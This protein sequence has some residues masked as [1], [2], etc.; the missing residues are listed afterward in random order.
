MKFH[1]PDMSCGHCKAAID[2]SVK[3]ADSSAKLE[4]DMD[5]RT[6]DIESQLPAGKILEALKTAGYDAAQQAA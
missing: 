1:V 3:G 6:V 4:F 2:S 5:N